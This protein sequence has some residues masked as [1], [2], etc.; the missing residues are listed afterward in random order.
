MYMYVYDALHKFM[1][2]SMPNGIRVCFKCSYKPKGI[3]GQH[4][5]KTPA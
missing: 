3:G 1:G 5:K 4:S 2:S